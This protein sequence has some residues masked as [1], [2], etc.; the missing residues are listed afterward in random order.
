MSRKLLQEVDLTIEL[1]YQNVNGNSIQFRIFPSLKI[2]V[3]IILLF[4]NI[5]ICVPNECAALF[6]HL[7]R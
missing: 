3:F 7:F 4:V 5:I 1:V 2:Y 6:L